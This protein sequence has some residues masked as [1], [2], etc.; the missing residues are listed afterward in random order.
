VPH[1]VVVAAGN[2]SMGD[3][4][5]LD[6]RSFPAAYDFPNLLVVMSHD[7]DYT[8]SR[9]S[10]WGEVSVD[11]A[12][13]GAGWSTRNCGRTLE[14]SCYQTSLYAMTSTST[15]FVS[16]AAAL[17]W[18]KYP[19][20]THAQIKERILENSIP[21]PT[22]A[23][24]STTGARLD[25][26]RVM[27]PIRI[28]G[29]ANGRI[30]RSSGDHRIFLRTAFPSNVCRTTTELEVRVGSN[31]RNDAV[32][33]HAHVLH[34]SSLQAGEQ[35][36]IKARCENAAGEPVEAESPLYTIE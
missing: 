16:G 14:K 8:V 30:K 18:S 33:S 31:T 17:L 26:Q 1:L 11:L 3:D 34:V 23:R 24:K 2:R 12:A 13:P 10:N 27:Y 36:R 5:D 9:M 21:E 35:M 29:A 4:G 32:N 25:L 19:D 15:A 22:L 20:W 28:I 7:A 6:Y